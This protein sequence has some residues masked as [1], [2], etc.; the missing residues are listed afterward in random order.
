MRVRQL[1]SLNWKDIDFKHRRIL[2]RAEGSKTHREWYI[3]MTDTVHSHLYHLRKQYLLAIKIT[4]SLAVHQQVF[5]FAV[6]SGRVMNG[7]TSENYVAKLFRQ[8][9]AMLPSPARI[10]THR[11]RHTVATELMRK[12]ERNVTHVRDL[13][14]HST[15]ATTCRYISPDLG[16]MASMLTNV[17]W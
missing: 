8:L 11:I 3:P 4:P 17:S 10:T 9:S 15:I 16:A 7:R 12:P 6:H 13:L 5:C 1:V 2:L 14:G